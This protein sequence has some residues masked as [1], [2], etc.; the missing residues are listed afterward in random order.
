MYAQASARR[1]ARADAERALLIDALAG[2]AG[3]AAAV[4]LAIGWVAV[5]AAAAGMAVGWAAGR[6]P[7]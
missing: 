1:E 4:A 6:L 3:P 2:K 5:A 7:R